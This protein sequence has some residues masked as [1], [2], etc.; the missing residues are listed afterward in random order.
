MF[1]F[2]TIWSHQG[3]RILRFSDDFGGGAG[4]G[5]VLNGNIMQKNDKDWY[6]PK[7]AI[8]DSLTLLNL[9][10]VKFRWYILLPVIA[11]NIDF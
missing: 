6:N 2:N 11:E 7:V 10:V 3:R 5:G 8:L 4:G 1:P 9:F